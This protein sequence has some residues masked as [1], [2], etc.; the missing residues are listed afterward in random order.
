MFVPSLRKDRDERA[1]LLD[2]VARAF[3]HGVPVDWRRLFAAPA[4]DRADLPTYPFQ[5]RRYWPK[6]PVLLGDVTA[7]GLGTSR[8]P[9][10]RRGRGAGRRRHP[11][12]HR[13]ALAGLPLLAGGPR[14]HR[15]RPVPGDR[16]PRPGPARGRPH[17]LRAGRRADDPGPAHPARA[18]RGAGPGPRRG[19]RRHRGPPADRARPPRRRRTRHLVDP[20][21]RRSAHGRRRNGGHP[22]RLHR[23][24]ARGRRRSAARRFLRGVRRPRLRSTARCSRD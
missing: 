8:S 22:L 5:R 11:R 1:T 24:A 14:P 3:A 12:V 2:A 18:R 7:A 4:P 10:A 20:P 9:A 17:R 23:L 16:L 21:R 19:T 13:P 6:P 15:H